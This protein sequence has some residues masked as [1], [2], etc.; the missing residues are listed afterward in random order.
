MENP[1]SQSQIALESY[2]AYG[3]RGRSMMAVRAP[4]ATSG[5]APDLVGR[6]ARIDGAAYRVIGISRQI[7]GPIAK[8]EPIGVEVRPLDTARSAA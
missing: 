1:A 7:S 6:I 3:Y 4:F 5:E 2:Y 8:G